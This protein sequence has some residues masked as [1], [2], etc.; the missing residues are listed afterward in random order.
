MED[1]FTEKRQYCIAK[2]PSEPKKK[3]TYSSIKQSINSLKYSIFKSTKNKSIQAKE[4]IFRAEKASATLVLGNKEIMRHNNP[5]NISN[6]YVP[7]E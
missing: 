7:D 2:Y 4:K 6:H 5:L 1:F 3:G